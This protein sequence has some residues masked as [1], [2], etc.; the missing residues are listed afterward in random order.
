MFQISNNSAFKPWKKCDYY[1][2]SYVELFEMIDESPDI[3]R[4]TNNK[5]LVEFFQ[6]IKIKTIN[7][8]LKL[9]KE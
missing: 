8:V 3:V 6:T 1:R 2:I 5:E 7:G 4:P 9:C